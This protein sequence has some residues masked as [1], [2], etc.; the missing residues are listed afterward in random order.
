MTHS[1]ITA[2]LVGLLGGLHC[3]GMCGGIVT[4]LTFSLPRAQ[5]PLARLPMQLGYNLGRLLGYGVMGALFGGLGD[6]MLAAL[7]LEQAQRLLYAAAALMMLL[8]GLYLGRWWP[9]L[10]RLEQLGIPLWRHLEPLGRRLL[11]LRHGWQALA[12]GFIWAWLPCG[13][14]YSVLI[15]ALAAGSAL[16]GA[17]LMLAFGLGTLPNLLGIG[18]LAGASARL[19]E[20]PWLNQL[21]GA[22]VIGFA[23]LAFWQLLAA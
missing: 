6:W 17:L 11:P 22:L 15:W 7:P 21:A 16:S 3:L 18:L 2:F 8:L 10:A 5:R 9:G 13:L 12:I 19:S 1:L 23:L 4:S 20:R 14:V